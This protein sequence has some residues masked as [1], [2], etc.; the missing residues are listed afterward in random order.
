MRG[1]AGF[2][3]W[4]TFQ[5]IWLTRGNMC[6]PCTTTPTPAP[7]PPARRFVLHPYRSITAEAPTTPP[8]TSFHRVTPPDG[9][10]HKPGYPAHWRQQVGMQVTE[11]YPVPVWAAGLRP[12]AAGRIPLGNLGTPIRR[13]AAP[14]LV[15]DCGLDVWIKRDDATGTFSWLGLDIDHS[16]IFSCIPLA[17][18]QRRMTCH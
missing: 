6:R 7:P 10:T 1:I 8:A 17:P 15:D 12:P 14:V 4:H 16:A 5:K 9:Q 2:N 11:P 13:F 3:F 18:R